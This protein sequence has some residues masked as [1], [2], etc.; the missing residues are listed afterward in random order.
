M[1]TIDFS[2]DLVLMF[3]RDIWNDAVKEEPEISDEM[4]FEEFVEEVRIAYP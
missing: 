4:T 3:L 1:N 2:S